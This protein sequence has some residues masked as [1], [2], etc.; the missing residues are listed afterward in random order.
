ME[1]TQGP[2]PSPPAPRACHRG[3]KGFSTVVTGSRNQEMVYM[4]IK[5]PDHP[6]SERNQVSIVLL[7]CRC[8]SGPV[9]ILEALTLGL[10]S[11]SHW[12]PLLPRG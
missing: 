8:L 4:D 9:V 5:L 2:R 1:W 11:K 3:V 6:L 7:R 12:V 10:I